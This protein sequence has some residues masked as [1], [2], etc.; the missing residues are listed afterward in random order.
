[1]L[2][3]RWDM[4][5]FYFPREN[6]YVQF[7]G[8]VYQQIFGIPVSTNCAPLIAD[9]F[10]FCYERDFMSN[11]HKSKR[12]NLIDMFNDT[13]RYLDDIFT[14]DNPEFEKHIPD[15]YPTEL[16]LNKTNSSD[17]RNFFPWFK[18]KSHWQWCPYQRLWQTR[19]LRISYRQFPLVEWWCS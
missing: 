5:S 8:M 11:L 4:W 14:I 10:L 15:I 17:K 16:Q 2:D 1:M 13:S 9:L 18:Y 12:Y 7:E 6:I 3:S 19:W